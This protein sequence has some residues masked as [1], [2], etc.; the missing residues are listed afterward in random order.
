MSAT[1]E[2]GLFATYPICGARLQQFRAV[3]ASA[4][5]T[6]HYRSRIEQAGLGEPALISEIECAEEV[7]ERL[8]RSE[9]AGILEDFEALRNPAGERSEPRDL[10]YPLDIPPRTAVLFPGFRETRHVLVFADNWSRKL[11]RYRPNASAGHSRRPRRSAAPDAR[12][13]GVHRN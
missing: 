8:P 4:A 13:G 9:L 12:R 7:L 10:C 11:K 5:R 3:L 2:C 6:R 1:K